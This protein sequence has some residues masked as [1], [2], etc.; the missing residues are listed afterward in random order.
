MEKQ[1]QISFRW[2]LTILALG[3]TSLIT[4]NILL[5]EFLSVFHGNELV[6]GIILANWMLLTGIG[7]Y[8]GKYIEKSGK[9]Y[10]WLFTS[11][12]LIGLFPVI[13]AFLINYLRNSF[14]LPGVMVGLFQIIYLSFLFLLPFCLLTGIFFTLLASMISDY[15]KTNL[16]RKV[17]AFEAIGSIIGGLLFNFVLIYR[18]DTFSGLLILLIINSII[19]FITASIYKPRYIRIIALLLIIAGLLTLALTDLTHIAKSYLHGNQ[20]LIYT[21]DSPYGNI[22]I[23]K[24]NGQFNFYENNQLTFS[25]NNTIQNEENTHYGMVQHPC[26]KN[27]LLISGGITGM[28]D[29]VAKYDVE[30]IDYVEMNPWIIKAGK[31]YTKNLDH[32][33]LNIINTDARLYIKET[34]NKYD[35]I[36]VNSADPYTAN[37]NRYYTIEFFRQLKN[38]STPQGVVMTSALGTDNYMGE[39]VKKTLSVIYKTFDKVFSNTLIIPGGQTYFIGSEKKP[40]IN[41]PDLIEQR[42]INNNYVNKHYL[43][44]NTLKQKNRQIIENLDHD[45][46]VNTDF[47]PVAYF[48]Q[49]KYWMS[50]FETKSWSIFVLL[51]GLLIF[52]WIRLD[53][54]SL[55]MFTAGFTSSSIELI[56]IMAFQVIYGYVYHVIGLFITIFMAGLAVGALY[57]YK[58]I[59]A[60]SRR[61]FRG[62]QFV[63]GAFTILVP[64]FL[65]SVKTTHT[66]PI[67]VHIIIFVLMFIAAGLTGMVF[68]L[69]SQLRKKGIAQTS[70]ETYSADLT[71][72]AIGLFLLSAFLLPMLG[73]IKVLF[74]VGGLNILC[75]LLLHIKK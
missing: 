61:N 51:S 1:V 19:V 69:A 72:S 9:K 14:F 13:T 32:E 62:L 28:I 2:I 57:Y 47:N 33:K 45:V 53:F 56:L 30:Q 36:L 44:L 27:V 26:P 60:I 43:S 37:I 74:L 70:A 59:P 41:I 21:K 24:A 4:Q 16:I 71:G 65:L 58:I 55:G 11:L 31:K 39:E 17:Y 7:A 23:T 12:I 40:D 38:I 64:F 52:F 6:I 3:I 22:S 25:T 73:I 29:E 48:M 15:Y 5:R 49:I 20:E 67:I 68:S 75:G 42:N 10:I 8:T 18:F 50:F 54:A 66:S 35:V 63:I 46:P 34:K